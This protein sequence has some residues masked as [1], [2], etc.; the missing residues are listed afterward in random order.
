MALNLDLGYALRSHGYCAAQR[1][2]LEHKEP[3]C[4][5]VMGGECVVDFP[6]RAF[7]ANSNTE[8]GI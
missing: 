5:A 2:F 3:D 6:R 8:I 4:P 1:H 7:F